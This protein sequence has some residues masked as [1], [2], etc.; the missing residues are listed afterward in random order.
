MFIVVLGSFFVVL[1]VHCGGILETLGSIL[2]TLGPPGRH[3]EAPWA[4]FRGPGVHFDP[5]VRAEATQ[6]RKPWF[7]GRPGASLLEHF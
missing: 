1:G 3:F 7:V 5:R 4:P 6:T 2:V